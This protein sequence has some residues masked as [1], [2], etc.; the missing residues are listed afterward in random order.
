MSQRLP[1]NGM[2]ATGE[3]PNQVIEWCRKDIHMVTAAM[4]MYN[5]FA[6]NYEMVP[7]VDEE[8]KKVEQ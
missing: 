4:M 1:I 3:S 6:A 5:Y 7:I 2:F 8:E